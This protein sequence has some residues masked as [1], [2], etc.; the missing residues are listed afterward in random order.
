MSI[1]DRVNKITISKKI[2]SEKIEAMGNYISKLFSDKFRF[3]LTLK[4]L[5]GEETNQGIYSEILQVSSLFNV[6]LKKVK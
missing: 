2:L 6:S 3:I 1:S 5:I 4:Y